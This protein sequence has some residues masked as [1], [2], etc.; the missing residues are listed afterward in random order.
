[1]N[2]RSESIIGREKAGKIKEHDGNEKAVLKVRGRWSVNVKEGNITERCRLGKSEGRVKTET[3]KE[4]KGDTD[5]FN[6]SC[7]L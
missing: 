6:N 3:E 7:V 1:M 5:G 2:L 4:K